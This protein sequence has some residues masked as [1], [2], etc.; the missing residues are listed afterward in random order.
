[1]VNIL[2]QQNTI[3]CRFMAELRDQNIQKDTMRFRRNMERVGEVM[4][5]EVSKKL[6]YTSREVVTPLGQATT[7]L[8]EE[9]IVLAT[10]LRAGVPMMNGFLNYFDR[11]EVAFVSAKRH[12]RKNGE[13]QILMQQ[14]TTPSLEG[15]ILIIID[16]MLAT[17]ASIEMTYHA[18]IEQGGVPLHT[19]ICAA[20][21]S[22]DGMEYIQSHLRATDVTLWSV[23]V[24]SDMTVKSYIVPGIGDTGDLAYG[25]KID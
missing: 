7:M 16:P 20:I 2:N 12:Y 21:S 18:L 10:I 14:I 6:T 11:A 5:Y 9:K 8:P 3:L 15:K 25:E 1:M 4:A 19:H 22:S 13:M 24:D 23:A 17:G